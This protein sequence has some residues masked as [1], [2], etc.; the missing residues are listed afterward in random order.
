[1]CTAR[2]QERLGRQ[3]CAQTAALAD[4]RST[5]CDHEGSERWRLPCGQS[6][7]GSLVFPSG[8]IGFARPSC[9]PGVGSVVSG[10]FGC[11]G[12]DISRGR[13]T[14]TTP[15][16]STAVSQPGHCGATCERFDRADTSLSEAS[17]RR[18][19][20]TP[21]PSEPLPQLPCVLGRGRTRAIRTRGWTTGS[22]SRI[23]RWDKV[24]VQVVSPSWPT[25][26]PGCAVSAAQRPSAASTC[27][28]CWSAALPS[29][30]SIDPD[31]LP[32]AH[33]P[34]GWGE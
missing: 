9:V 3:P 4:T 25:S 1:M 18:N 27:P 6:S 32:S 31:P 29:R 19:G 20:P 8:A 11:A 10:R 33:S 34:S 14:D 17:R 2:R 7:A 15:P 26:L 22:M 12:R 21:F 30:R 16:A 13:E 28:L 5:L 24:I 23:G